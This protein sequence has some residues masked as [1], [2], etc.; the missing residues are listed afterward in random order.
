MYIG[1]TRLGTIG[2]NYYRGSLVETD[3]GFSWT[4]KL[5]HHFWV[6][7]LIM[8]ILVGVS[9]VL[10]IGYLVALSTPIFKLED[11]GFKGIKHVSQTELLQKGGLEN[12]VNLL[13]LNL[14]EVKKNMESIPWVK[15][16]SLQRELP[17]KL[18]VIVTEHQA[19]FLVPIRQDLYYLNEEGC[20]FK[21]CE[22][23]EGVSLP[24]LTGLGGKDWTPAGQLN[25]SILQELVSLLG[26]LS[27]GADPFYPNKLSEIHYDPDCGFSLFTCERGI[28]I[29]LGKEEI[30]V[31]IKRLEKVWAELE[32]RPNQLLLKGISLQ[33]GQR[34]I[35][36]GLR[37]KSFKKV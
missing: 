6:G 15:R 21:K 31:Q 22:L 26:Y 12:R 10:L 17:N 5:M 7:S 2:R 8:M 4:E 16:V 1:K 35:V 13:A 25:S 23:K 24:L 28:R 30:P 27:Q 33:F 14:G 11:V 34:I 32:K 20:L 3:P 29:T 37:S 19:K 9:I 36:H 18:Q